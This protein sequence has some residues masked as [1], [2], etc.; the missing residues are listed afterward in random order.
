ME[1]E[2]LAIG[3]YIGETN[4]CA[5]VFRNGKVDIIPN[6]L[7]QHLTPS[8][9]SFDE[10]KGILVGE[11]ALNKFI[12]DPKKTIHGI[13]RLMGKDFRDI[14]VMYNI[15]NKFWEFDIIEK[16]ENRRS[17]IKIENKLRYFYYPEEIYS[18]IIRKLIKSA[19]QYLQQKIEKV[20]LTV[21]A[22]FNIK[23]REAT[24]FAAEQAGLKII[25]I[26]NE[27][28][29]AVLAYG[30]EK[31]SSNTFL[32][33]NETLNSEEQES[34][35][36][37]EII[38]KEKKNYIAIFDLGGNTFDLTL[39]K[40]KDKEEYDIYYTTGDK[41]LGG[42]D[43]TKKIM[44]YCLK[45]FST[46]FKFNLDEIRKNEEA[47]YRLKNAAENAKI[48]LSFE[49]ETSIDIDD[50]YKQEALHIKLTKLL[51][52]D[53]CQDLY[54]KIID[55]L[56]ELL[57]KC[58]Y[59]NESIKNVIFVGGSSRIPRVKEIVKNYFYDIEICD[60]INEEETKAYGAVMYAA[61]FYK[62]GGEFF[63]DLSFKG[64]T[65][66]SLGINIKNESEKQEIKNKG[67]LMNVVFPKGTP[68]PVLKTIKYKTSPNLQETVTIGVYEGEN[69]Y[70]KDNHFL[71]K[72]D[73]LNLP[74]KKE[75]EIEISFLINEYMILTVRASET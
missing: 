30:L 45:E 71:G 62:Q 16:K 39:L 44:D 11:E 57:D 29:A 43:F 40:I 19:S 10:E 17:L 21:P 7:G 50:F 4:S 34:K 2:E 52:E 22:Y 65:P 72:L 14:S 56:D 8:I 46:K 20:V 61:K 51:F 58:P 60:S 68:I 28:S 35:N 27:P 36:V 5:A 42:N 6:E 31:K 26:I 64:K 73:L 75:V 24:Q 66:F 38:D 25:K 48:R 37:D 32:D 33:I 54:K 13:K 74:S 9:V 18:I 55:C 63:T 49:K 59:S 1:D 47:M 23:Q 53:L 12:K 67:D 3:I 41:Y 70:V 69:R 15:R